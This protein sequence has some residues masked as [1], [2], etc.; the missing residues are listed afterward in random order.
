MRFQKT[1]ISFYLIDEYYNMIRFSPGS[2]GKTKS[3][4][5]EQIAGLGA[6]LL[7]VENYYRMTNNIDGLNACNYLKN[8]SAGAEATPFS[9][10]GCVMTS[11]RDADDIIKDKLRGPKTRV[12]MTFEAGFMKCINWLAQHYGWS[13]SYTMTLLL[14]YGT[15]LTYYSGD[16]EH[17]PPERL[18]EFNKIKD[19]T[20]QYSDSY[21]VTLNKIVESA[22]MNFRDIQ[23][24]VVVVPTPQ[25]KTK[26]PKLQSKEVL[27]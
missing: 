9:I 1:P 8:M 22:Q 7:F 23:N 19:Y 27:T 3:H 14:Q 6:Q 11:T 17:Y 26:T 21:N 24:N 12:C 10:F 18:N 2:I 25:T 4:I 20:V 5:I 15:A 16:T 13:T